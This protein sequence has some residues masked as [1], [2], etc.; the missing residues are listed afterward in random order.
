VTEPQLL[1][2]VEVARFLMG[3]TRRLD[4]LVG[5]YKAAGRRAAETRKVAEL[6]EARA[7]LE[8]DDEAGRRVTIDERK[9]RAIIASSEQRFLADLADKE[10]TT[11]RTAIRALEIRIDVGR[12]LSATSRAEMSMGGG[13]Q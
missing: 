1:T 3:L 10:F 7:W 12:T 4:E 13:P 11:C 9:R 6:A 8:A 2:P 5:E